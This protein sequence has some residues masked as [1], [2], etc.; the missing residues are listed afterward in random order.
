[1]PDF[2][3]VF[4]DFGLTAVLLSAAVM[5]L[6]GFT[7]GAVGF[8]LPMVAV[9]GI[10]SILPAPVAV[11]ALML[12]AIVTNLWQ[13]LRD[14]VGPARASLHRFRRLTMI[15]VLVMACVAPLVAI[16]DPVVLLTVLGV[17]ITFFAVI[18]LAGWRPPAELAATRMAEAVAGVLA[19]IAGGLAAVTGPAVVM[20][21]IARD[22]PKVEQVRIQGLIFLLGLLVITAIHGLTGVMNSVTVALS[23]ILI[24]PACLGMWAGMVVQR[25]L[26]QAAFR[27]ATLV[28]LTLAGLNLLRRGLFG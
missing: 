24:A 1:M 28:V 14:G 11:A 13:G 19:G 27:R 8:A 16:L 6:A 25:R 15:I 12:P 22:V 20:Y 23:L 2:T 7:K 3:A 17:G 10:G 18:Q 5:F 9:S 26:D 4:D 21:L